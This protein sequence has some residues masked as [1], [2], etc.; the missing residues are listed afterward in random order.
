MPGDYSRQTFDPRKHYAGVLMQQGRVQLDA[1]WNEQHSIHQHRDVTETRDVVGKCGAPLAGGGFNLTLIDG[2]RDLQISPGRIYVDGI[3]CELEQEA[4]PAT[5]AS[6]TPLKLQ[7]CSLVVDG[8]ALAQGDWVELFAQGSNPGTDAVRQI[9]FVDPDK[10]LITLDGDAPT[11]AISPPDN[12]RLRRVVTFFTQ[13]DYPDPDIDGLPPGSMPDVSSPALPPGR[14]LAYLDVWQREITAL[15]DPRIREVALGGPDTATR[16]Q[17]MQQ[18]R[19]FALSTD[20]LPAP[21][22]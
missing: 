15:D 22:D 7:L 3:L 1:D 14:Y 18:V 16:L 10:S 21:L 13:P 11:V 4:V 8:R 12:L 19:L 17:T 2:G 20:S 5:V 9:M 6:T